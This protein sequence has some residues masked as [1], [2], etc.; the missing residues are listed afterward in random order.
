M[1]TMTTTCMYSYPNKTTTTTATMS[2]LR[3]SVLLLPLM[4][5][6]TSL[7]NTASFTFTPSIK[8]SHSSTAATGNNRIIRYPYNNNPSSSSSQ[9]RHK[10]TSSTSL[11]SVDLPNFADVLYTA[12][13]ATANMASSNMGSLNPVQLAV[14]YLA[15]LFTSFSP[16]AMGLL[17]LTMSYIS[18]ATG[19]R[20]DKAA[21]LPTLAFTAGLASVFVVLG[22]SVSFLGGIFGQ[23][24]GDVSSGVGN[25]LGTIALVGLSSG[26]S[27]AMGLQLLEVIDIPLPSFE[28]NV[29]FQ[30]ENTVVAYTPLDSCSEAKAAAER[31]NQDNEISSLVATFL[32]GGSSALVA[33]PC[34]TPVL[35]SILAFVAASQDPLVGAVLLFVYTIG[36]STPLVVVGATGGQFLVNMSEG[37]GVVGK[38]GS[39]VTPITASVLIYYGVIGLLKAC[40]GD[41]SI[42]GLM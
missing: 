42:A 4:L 33:S 37:D 36:Y 18:T 41:P 22:L 12:Q 6:I 1:T 29:P 9:H 34:A 8:H 7:T 32:L 31:N 26:V 3:R 40:F 2:S 10:S 23:T 30:N 11:G 16:C 39:F 15:G 38:I 21:F 28:V 35:T 25:L 20:E 27:I 24:G 5:W 17:P 14:L 19:G 13:S